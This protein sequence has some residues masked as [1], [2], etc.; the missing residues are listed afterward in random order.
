[1]ENSTIQELN[2]EADRIIGNR[3]LPAKSRK[4]RKLK[5]KNPKLNG[6]PKNIIISITAL[7]TLKNLNNI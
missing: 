3:L 4:N 2:A 6:N 7:S 5:R 1:M